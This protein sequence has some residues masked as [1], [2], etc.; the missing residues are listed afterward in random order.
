MASWR[1]LIGSKFQTAEN[2]T[3]K[4]IKGKII[5]CGPETVDDKDGGSRTDLF[6]KLNNHE[7][8]FR[9][10]V[11]NAESLSAKFGEDYEKWIGKLIEIS[12]VPTQMA[13]KPC[14][15]FKMKPLGK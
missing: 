3:K 8:M 2:F 5:S 13:G 10:N 4:S 6:L 1:D 9:V 15:G 11:G 7:K 12:V 14:K